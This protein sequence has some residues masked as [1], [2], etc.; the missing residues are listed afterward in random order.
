MNN[1]LKVLEE[2]KE[3]MLRQFK[4]NLA[5]EAKLLEIGVNDVTI[6]GPRNDIEYQRMLKDIEESGNGTEKSAR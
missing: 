3:R 4:L 5:A 2:N 6:C 1:P